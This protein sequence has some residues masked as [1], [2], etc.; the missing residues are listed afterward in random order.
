[1]IYPL[2][3]FR[4]KDNKAAR[5]FAEEYGLEATENHHLTAEGLIAKMYEW[6]ESE[7]EVEAYVYDLTKKEL[8]SMGYKMPKDIRRVK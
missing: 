6:N 4:D 5:E 8:E 1:M 2:S 3:F 7:H